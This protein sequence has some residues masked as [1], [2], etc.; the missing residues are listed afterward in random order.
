MAGSVRKFTLDGRTNELSI[1]DL[2]KPAPFHSGNALTVL[3][4]VRTL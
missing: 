3:E 1:V 2:N 4:I